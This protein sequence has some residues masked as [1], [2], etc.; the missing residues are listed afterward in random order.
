M[1]VEER[2]VRIV[3]T[4]KTHR[5]RRYRDYYLKIHLPEYLAERIEEYI[6]RIDMETGR[7]TLEPVY[8]QK[9]SEGTNG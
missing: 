2:R 8:R 4:T 9:E 7:I 5:G 3:R 6:A 1:A